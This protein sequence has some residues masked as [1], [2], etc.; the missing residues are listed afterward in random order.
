[1]NAFHDNCRGGSCLAVL[2]VVALVAIFA[3]VALRRSSSENETAERERQAKAAAEKTPEQLQRERFDEIL[4]AQSPDLGEDPA[5]KLVDGN[6]ATMKAVRDETVRQHAIVKARLKAAENDFERCRGELKTIERKLE[7]LKDEFARHPDDEAVGDE[8]AQCD[9]DL[10][11]K[12]R[13][14]IQVQTDI[15]PLKDY[16]YKLGREIAALSSA[17]RRCE[18]DGRT[19]ATTVEFEELKEDLAAADG[20]RAAMEELRRN[21]EARITDIGAEVSGEQARKRERLEKY[22]SRPAAAEAE[23]G[24]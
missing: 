13:E 24:R 14:F 2:A 18:A 12:R 9:E 19:I 21:Q 16:D 15:K 8:L 4:T 22:R 10:E 6:L 7:L 17:I 20:A 23:G 3:S 1:M 11:N 5:K